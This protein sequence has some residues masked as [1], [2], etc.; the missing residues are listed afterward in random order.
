MQG[1]ETPLSTR[2][3]TL[4]ATD[5]ES[6]AQGAHVASFLA[7]QQYK[8]R[9]LL[10]HSAFF[11]KRLFPHLLSTEK[12]LSMYSDS[13]HTAQLG[14]GGTKRSE[15]HMQQPRATGRAVSG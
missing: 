2:A 6:L 3:H 9:F 5:P 13:V 15:A 11:P 8:S 4:P 10:R 14:K 7:D 1:T 12:M